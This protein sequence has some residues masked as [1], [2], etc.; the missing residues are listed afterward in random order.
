[1]TQWEFG[2]EKTFVHDVISTN[3]QDPTINAYG[4]IVG[5]AELSGNFIELLDP[6]CDR[7]RIS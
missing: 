1:M 2:T 7:V 6:A 3:R 4:P 5:V